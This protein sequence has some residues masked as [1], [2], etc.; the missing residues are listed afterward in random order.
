MCAQEVGDHHEKEL[1][2]LSTPH[3][4]DLENV[5]CVWSYLPVH[6]RL[7]EQTGKTEESWEESQEQASSTPTKGITSRRNTRRV[8]SSDTVG[9]GLMASPIAVVCV[10]G[11]H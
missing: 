7:T 1:W 4:T 6:A 9:G 5:L 8:Q 11:L 3:N 10:T 2:R